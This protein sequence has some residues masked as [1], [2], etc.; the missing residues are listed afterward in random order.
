MC[1]SKENGGIS[2][3]DIQCFNQAFLAK[4]AWRLI[5]EPECLFSQVIKSRYYPE[6]EIMEAILG[7]RPS[8]GWR[9]ILY[10]R[11]LLEH[12]ISKQI[13]NGESFMVWTDPWIKIVNGE[14]LLDGRFLLI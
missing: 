3:R 7:T 9:S 8:Y 5:Q 10:G 6:G 13:G 14:P 12:G 4:Q 2:F 11:D 1:L